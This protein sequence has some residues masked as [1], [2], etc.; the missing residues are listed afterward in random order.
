MPKCKD[1]KFYKPVD[2]EKGDC[3]GH[4]LPAETD[5]DDC[6]TKSFQSRFESEE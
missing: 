1:C 2:D 3:F 6:P 4:K 5:A